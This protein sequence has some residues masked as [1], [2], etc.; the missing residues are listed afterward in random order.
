M[1]DQ[2]FIQKIIDIS[3][4]EHMTFDGRSYTTKPI[5]P[6]Y[7][8]TPAELKISTLTGLADY[9][10]GDLDG[11]KSNLII[12]V[13]SPVSVSVISKLEDEW[14]TRKHYIVAN[15]SAPIM[16]FGQWHSLESFNI[17]LQSMFV[18]TFDRGALLRLVGNVKEEDIQNYS[19]D[20]VT[21]SVTAKSGVARVEEVPVP[22]PVTLAPYRTF[23]EIIQPFS[24]FVFRM[25]NG[26]R[27][28]LF[29]ADG[30]A[31]KADAMLSIA[32]WLKDNIP[33]VP[34][35]A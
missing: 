25:Q 20:G 29:E 27:A 32:K 21:Q 10:N 14:Q 19:D 13:N 17:L 22:N 6:V 2:T 11:V 34:V 5:H 28:A 16:S 12:M 23:S 4:T 8:P 30:G 35:I 18:D 31:W 1:I 24:R 7:N 15:A 33:D 26:P 3:Q 9:I